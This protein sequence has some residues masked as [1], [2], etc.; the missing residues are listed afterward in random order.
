MNI[1]QELP[2]GHVLYPQG[3]TAFPVS[4]EKQAQE[5]DLVRQRIF[6][7]LLHYQQ[8]I[9]KDCSSSCA[10]VTGFIWSDFFRCFSL[11]VPIFTLFNSPHILCHITYNV[12]V[13]F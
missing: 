11:K 10:N 1:L 6:D 4:P 13:L 5:T 12:L 8:N 7:G 2:T 3:F 9:C